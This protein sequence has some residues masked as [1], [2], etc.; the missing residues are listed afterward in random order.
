VIVID[1]GIRHVSFGDR[2]FTSNIYIKD[3]EEILD[4]AHM[5]I[6]NFNSLFTQLC[7][8]DE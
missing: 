2:V 4:A 7:I 5:A 3:R 8:Q 1:V 6:E